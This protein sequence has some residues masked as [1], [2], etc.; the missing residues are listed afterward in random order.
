MERYVCLH[1]LPCA[2]ETQGIVTPMVGHLQWHV[3]QGFSVNR[4]S[5]HEAN[6]LGHIPNV[7]GLSFHHNKLLFAQCSGM[8][9]MERIAY[10][11][12]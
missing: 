5:H 7:V 2:I 4:G 8:A 9:Q 12:L 3:T 6:V 1:G 10:A 11:H